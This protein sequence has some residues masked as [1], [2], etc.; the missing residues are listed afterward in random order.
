MSPNKLLL[1]DFLNHNVRC[2]Q[3]IDHG[4]G[5][6]AWMHPPVHRLLG[7]I[8]RPSSLRLSRE[9][10]RLDQFKGIG[11]Q[12]VFVKGYPSISDQETLDRFPTLIDA[13]VFNNSGKRLGLVADMVFEPL[14]GKILYYLVSRTNPKIPGTSRWKLDIDLINDQQ[15]GMISCNI[16]TFYDLPIQKAS[17][18]QELLTKTRKWRTKIEDITYKANDQLEGWLDDS[19]WEETI[20]PLKNNKH[21]I[22]DVSFNDWVD[23]SDEEYLPKKNLFKNNNDNDPWI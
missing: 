14:K 5:V 11:T 13:N 7:W 16:S 1:S 17:L 9:V 20:N 6:M 8:S 19:D 15:P 2:D 21:S 3:G 22:N 23:Q 18:R 12:E 10:W 4:C